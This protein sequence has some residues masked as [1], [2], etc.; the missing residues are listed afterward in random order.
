[1][2]KIT[3]GEKRIYKIYKISRRDGISE[4]KNT[5][6]V[7]AREALNDFCNVWSIFVYPFKK[8]ADLAVGL[9][10]GNVYLAIKKEQL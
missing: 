4:L 2:N 8:D 7:S 3:L 5:K 1:M 6:A 10:D 9:Y